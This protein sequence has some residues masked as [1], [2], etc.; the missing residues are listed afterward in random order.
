MIKTDLELFSLTSED[1]YTIFE[2]MQ[3]GITVYRT[4]YDNS[5]KIRDLIIKYANP[6]SSTSKVFLNKKFT[7]KSIT[8]LYGSKAVSS[9]LREANEIV[10]TGQI[11]KYETYS[12]FIDSYFSIS[13]FSPAKNLYVTLTADITEQKKAENYLQNANNNLE[14]KVQERTKELSSALQEKELLLREIHHRVNNSLQLISSLINIQASYIKDEKS[15]EFF[16]ESQNRVK[17]ISMIHEKLYQSKNL[18][19]IDF[20]SY[21]SSIVINLFQVYVID[22]EKIKYDLKCNNI[23]LNMETAIP[24][25]LII[26]ELIT[27]SLKHAFGNEISVELYSE[28]ET[29]NFIVKDNGIGFPEDLDFRN[30]ESLGLQLVNLLVNQLDGTIELENK[31]GTEFKIKFNELEY[32]ERINSKKSI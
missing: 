10:S 21:L 5:G 13:A 4:I 23:K 6:A 8:K 18:Q 15:I 11:K 26:T 27:N 25:G 9:F 24:C 3:E 20:S 19:K 2:N 12:P 32:R 16:K 30:T 31:E 17:S 7:G 14:F 28:N 29:F 1:Y 22:Q